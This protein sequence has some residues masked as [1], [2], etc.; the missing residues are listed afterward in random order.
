MTAWLH[1]GSGMEGSLVEGDMLGVSWGNDC[2]FGSGPSALS[3]WASGMCALLSI[4]SLP[5]EVVSTYERE[6][7]FTLSFISAGFHFSVAGS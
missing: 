7:P 4:S 6:T 1:G 2:S 3:W 5:V